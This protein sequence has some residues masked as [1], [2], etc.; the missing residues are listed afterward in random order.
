VPK[1]QANL[2]T[3][4]IIRKL[5]RIIGA[6]QTQTRNNGSEFSGYQ[7]FSK[8]L[9]LTSYFCSPY[10]SSQR[11]SNENMGAYSLS[12]VRIFMILVPP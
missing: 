12:R 9:S 6:V 4:V 1:L 3:S 11:G 5:R 10:R 7:T 8:A 2:V